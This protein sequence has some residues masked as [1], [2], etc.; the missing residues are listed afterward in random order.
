MPGKCTNQKKDIPT[1]VTGGRN[2][3]FTDAKKSEVCKALRVMKKAMNDTED[4]TCADSNLNLLHHA[5]H[6]G[7]AACKEREV[8]VPIMSALGAI[9]AL[10]VAAAIYML[11]FRKG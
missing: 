5:Q 11:F 3:K 10:L 6:H 2:I 1:V 8:H 4:A 7:L 9:A